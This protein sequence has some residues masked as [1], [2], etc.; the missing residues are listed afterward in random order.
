MRIE[1]GPLEV[2]CKRLFFVDPAIGEGIVGGS[3]V[4]IFDPLVEMA[5]D[6]RQQDGEIEERDQR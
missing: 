1:H 4:W 2:G 3:S 5:A 6:K